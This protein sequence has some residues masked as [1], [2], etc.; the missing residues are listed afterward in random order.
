[1][2]PHHLQSRLQQKFCCC[3]EM[4]IYT[5]K[6]AQIRL[7]VFMTGNWFDNIVVLLLFT[8]ITPPYFKDKVIWNFQMIVAWN[9]HMQDVLISPH[10]YRFNM[11]QFIYETNK[12]TCP[13]GWGGVCFSSSRKKNNT[14]GK[15]VGTKL[16]FLFLEIERYQNNVQ[17]VVGG[18]VF[19]KREEGFN[20][21]IMWEST[22]RFFQRGQ[23]LP[24]KKLTI[25][26]WFWRTTIP[27]CWG[28]RKYSDY[29]DI[30][31]S[32]C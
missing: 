17:R 25:V 22:K 15:L 3:W 24:G 9:G 1:M 32:L 23:H 29:T 27:H 18:L 12:F 26:L 14:P 20:Q 4:S 5:F 6:A 30:D 21:W 11:S 13:P 19:W 16:R 8:D 31:I 28:N 7:D 10:M 2:Y